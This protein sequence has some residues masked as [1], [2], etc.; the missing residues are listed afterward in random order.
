M[1]CIARQCRY[2]WFQNHFN[3]AFVPLFFA[4]LFFRY[5]V[6]PAK[7]MGKTSGKN[8]VFKFFGGKFLLN[9]EKAIKPEFV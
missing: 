2:C 9:P 7:K 4:V 8:N 6:A 5:L 3:G 1:V